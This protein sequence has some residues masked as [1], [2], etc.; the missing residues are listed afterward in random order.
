LIDGS[1]ERG[2]GTTSSGVV[3]QRFDNGNLS[4]SAPCAAVIA[5][6]EATKIAEISDNL[7]GSVMNAPPIAVQ[8]Q[9]LTWRQIVAP[10]TH[11]RNALSNED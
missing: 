10:L 5:K 1:A 6:W 2:L 9:E 11:Y 8:Y 4:C 3:P 7:M